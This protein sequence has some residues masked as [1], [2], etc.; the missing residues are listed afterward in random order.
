MN[1]SGAPPAERIASAPTASA[2]PDLSRDT[3]TPAQEPAQTH[4]SGDP[5]P[6]SAPPIPPARPKAHFRK[7]VARVHIRSVGAASP[8]PWQN[9]SFP[10]TNPPWPGYDDKSTGATATKK[11]AGKLTG[12]VTNRPQ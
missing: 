6:V 10:A 11:T 3:R 5:L 8:Q 12:T 4:A 9:S 7:K 2:E 1:G